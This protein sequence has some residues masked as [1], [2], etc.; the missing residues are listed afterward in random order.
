[1]NLYSDIIFDGRRF[2]F[3]AALRLDKDGTI[4]QF[5]SED[6]FNKNDFKYFP[7]LI[8]PGFINAHCH[9]ELS[10]L[11]GK[12]NTGTGLLAFLGSVVSQRETEQYIIDAAIEKADQEM[13]NNGIVAV[14]DISNKSDTIPC[15]LKSKI[16]YYNFIECFDFLQDSRSQEFFTPYQ[17]LYEQY[18]AL[19]KS[20]SP[21]APYS[22]SKSL[23]KLIKENNNLD[24]IIS[25]HNQEVEDEDLLFVDKSGG[26]EKF[27]SQFGFSLTHFQATGKNSVYYAMEN[28]PSQNNILFI[29]NTCMNQADIE[30]AIRWNKNSYFVTC[31]NANL[32]IENRLPNYELFSRYQDHIC[33]GTDSYSSNWTLS[34][35]DEIKTILQYQSFLSLEQVLQWACYNGARAFKMEKEMGTIDTY[36]RPGLNWIQDVYVENDKVKLGTNASVYKLA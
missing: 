26:F 13:F 7:G 19:A 24:S 30:Q 35:L 22:V 2:H 27:F 33:I 6:Q 17:N 3:N 36:K 21:H 5:L 12:F 23:F 29:H 20:Y 18:Q 11:K 32:F 34:I 25:I 9:L 28:L 14:G 1:M 31:P 10:H 8:L 16:K 4:I 15:K